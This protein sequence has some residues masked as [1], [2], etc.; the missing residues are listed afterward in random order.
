MW[1]LF[2]CA[3]AQNYQIRLDYEE[4]AAIITSDANS[5]QESAQNITLQ[6]IT[7]RYTSMT[8]AALLAELPNCF[9]DT[10]REVDKMNVTSQ[11]QHYFSIK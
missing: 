3:F 11:I 6:N 10:V 2:L 7:E 8:P 4:I 5:Q 9:W 1:W